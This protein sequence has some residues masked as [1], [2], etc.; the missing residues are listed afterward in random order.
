MHLDFIEISQTI[1]SFDNEIDSLFS[2]VDE[3]YSKS[4][5]KS[6]CIAVSGGSDSL[7][8]LVLTSFWAKKNNIDIFCGTIDHQ[9]RAESR[10]EAEHVKSICDKLGIYHEILTWNHDQIVDE[11]KL[12]NL[13]RQARYNLLQ[14][15]CEKHNIQFISTGHTWNDQLETYELRKNFGSGQSG[16]AGM[17]QVRSIADNI[18]IIRPLL[19]FSK[20]HLQDFLQ[21]QCIRWKTDPMNFDDVFLRVA[22]RKKIVEYNKET[23]QNISNKIL[24]FGEQRYQI[25]KSA[26]KFLREN[27]EISNYGYAEIKLDSLLKLVTDVQLEVIRRVVWQIGGKQYLSSISYES[28]KDILNRKINTIGRCLI[29]ISKNRLLVFRENRN[30][31]FVSADKNTVIWDNRFVINLPPTLDR[32]NLFIKGC[33]VTNCIESFNEIP[34]NALPGFPCLSSNHQVEYSFDKWVED[35]SFIIRPDLFDIFYG[36]ESA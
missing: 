26:V 23:I 21:H 10:E 35:V 5:N 6:V 18:K 11:G 15:F 24:R 12:E 22:A 31:P 36:G 25:E 16:L 9:L 4:N 3:H 30:V 7:A 1:R 13:A 29:K 2:F 19:H 32:S 28:L 20:K 8:L 17:S 27:V 14:A 33:N 34:R